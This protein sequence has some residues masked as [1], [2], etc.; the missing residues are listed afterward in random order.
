MD[1]QS[2]PS[3]VAS[4]SGVVCASPVNCE[5][6]GTGTNFGGTIAT[7]SAPPNVTTTSLTVG[8]IG[9]PY[10][11]S[12]SASGG[13]APYGWAVAGG[14]LPPGIHVAPTGVL[15]GTPTISGHYDRHFQ[16]DR[17][18]PLFQPGNAR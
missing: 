17:L 3:G 14:T 1:A 18:Q 8:T 10:E 11:A 9:V 7:L 6:V 2:A 16:R 15:S 5:A 4:L 13:L 12:L